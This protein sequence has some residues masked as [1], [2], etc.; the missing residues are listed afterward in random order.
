M[1]DQ[2]KI[3]A[4][5]GLILVLFVLW[6]VYKPTLSAMLFNAPSSASDIFLVPPVNGDGG[7]EEPNTGNGEGNG[8]NGAPIDPAPET[9][10]LPVID[11]SNL[12][13]LNS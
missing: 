5:M 1:N 9:P 13:G 10:G 11:A 4:T 2:E 6:L 8:S 3:V 7:G 12:P